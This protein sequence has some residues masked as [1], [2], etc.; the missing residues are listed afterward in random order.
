VPGDTNG[1]GVVDVTDLLDVLAAWGD[2]ADICDC[3]ADV[4]GDGVV[5]VSDLLLV[6]GA[7]S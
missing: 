2:C 3:P 6:L 7:W 5:D 1:D 4:T